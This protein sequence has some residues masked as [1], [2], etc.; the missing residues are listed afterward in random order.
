MY[1]EIMSER[2]AGRPRSYDAP[3]TIRLTP[4]VREAVNQRAKVERRTPADMLRLLIERGLHA[5]GVE[6][7]AQE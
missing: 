6:F 5:S 7:G 2:K 1:A 3:T 4:V